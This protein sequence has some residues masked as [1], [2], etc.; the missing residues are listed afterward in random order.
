MS[1]LS[2]TIRHRRLAAELRRLR[3]A[4]DLS[5]ADG[6]A[7]LGISRPQLVKI[8]TAKIKPPL[9]MVKRILDKWGRNEAHTLAVMAVARNIHE[10]SWWQ[11]AGGYLSGDF[12]ELEEDADRMDIWNTELVPGL[13]QTD[14]YARA[15]ISSGDL[16]DEKEIDERVKVRMRRQAVLS[17]SN[18]PVLNVVLDE[19]V[20]HRSIGGPEVMRGQLRALLESGQRDNISIRILPADTGPHAG[21]GEGSF[22]IFGFPRPMDLDVAYLESSAGPIYV[23]EKVKVDRSRFV[24]GSI[25]DQSLTVEKSAAL[26]RTRIEE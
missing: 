10:L 14:E 12:A 3:N 20:L 4:A 5:P 13:L 24:H 7:A 19:A 15:L 16:R 8:E 6:A 2:P 21:I 26:I 17:G 9:P 18:P 1:E 11:S 25:T 23:E 22:T